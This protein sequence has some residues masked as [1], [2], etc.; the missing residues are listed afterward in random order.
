MKQGHQSYVELE[1]GRVSKYIDNYNAYDE[2]V[3]P[4]REFKILE[5]IST[6]SPFF[7][8]NVIEKGPY[9]IEYDY[10][11]GKNLTVLN[12]KY[13]IQIYNLYKLLNEHGFNH[14]DPNYDNFIIDNNDNIHII[15]FGFAYTTENRGPLIF[16][17]MICNNDEVEYTPPIQNYGYKTFPITKSFY[18]EI[19]NLIDKAESEDRHWR[20]KI[21]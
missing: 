4:W 12:R 11:E 6:I 21:I 3:E 15:D 17:C 16:G 9:H 10:I 20:E 18:E 19:D 14:G 7:P 8:Q 13:Y 2:Y 1:N 5:Y